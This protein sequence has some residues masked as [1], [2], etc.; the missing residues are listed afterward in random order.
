MRPPLHARDH[1][2]GDPDAPVMLV[3]F[4]DFECPHCSRAHPVVKA[5]V[6]QLGDQLCFAFRHFPL[7]S[8]HPHAA[9][10]AEAA[11][12]AGAQQ[13]FW[14]MHD[15]LY[16]NQDALD[17]DE[18]VGYAKLA[19]LDVE[20]FVHDL[21][22]HRFRDRVRDDLR[23]GALSGAGGTPTFFINDVRHD[24]GADFDSLWRAIT[25]AEDVPHRHP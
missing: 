25:G 16:E 19:G 12:A 23:S 1:L 7:T 13:R 5:L 11:E 3:E 18:L 21:R 24:G 9:L 10:A 4:G 17:L 8:V 15:L 14:E 22:V 2:L 6:Q 20:R